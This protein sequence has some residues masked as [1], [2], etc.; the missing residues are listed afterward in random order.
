MPIL[1]FTFL[2]KF[3]FYCVLNIGGDPLGGF[4]VVILDKHLG[5]DACLGRFNFDNCIISDNLC[6]DT[7]KDRSRGNNKS[8]KC[9]NGEKS[10]F[11]SR[12]RSS[13]SFK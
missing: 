8:G 4:I 2:N 10:N 9:L 1:I 6:G 13:S 7:G 12:F 3:R 11:R 5:G